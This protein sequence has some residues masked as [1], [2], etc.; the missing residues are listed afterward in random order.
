MDFQFPYIFCMKFTI[1]LMQRCDTFIA[2]FIFCTRPWREAHFAFEL[3][4]NNKKMKHFWN[5]TTTFCTR[6]GR[7]ANFTHATFLQNN[8]GADE[9]GGFYENAT[10]NFLHTSRTGSPFWSRITWAKQLMAFFKK[11]I[12]E[13]NWL[14]VPDVCKKVRVA[15]SQN[16]PAVPS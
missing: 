10:R 4:K 12:H 13:Q 16:R 9:A 2:H 14:P 3:F 8:F 5:L 11:M 6:L 15:L 7:E 1:V